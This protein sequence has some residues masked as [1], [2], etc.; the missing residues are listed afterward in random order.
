MRYVE[1]RDAV[2][3]ELRRHPAG[4]TWKELRERLALPYERACPTWVARL[5]EEIGLERMRDAGRAYVWTL[6]AGK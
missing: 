4:W 5:E 2:R 6:P 3:G 1:F